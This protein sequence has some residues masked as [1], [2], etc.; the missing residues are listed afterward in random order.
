MHL[1]SNNLR[2][3]LALLL[4]AGG[5]TFA[6]IELA[7]E[8]PADP[9]SAVT[10]TQNAAG[11]LADSNPQREDRPLA[12]NASTH[13]EATQDAEAPATNAPAEI[14]PSVKSDAAPSDASPAPE[15]ELPQLG[16]LLAQLEA[17]W[18]AGK[19]DEIASIHAKLQGFAPLSSHKLFVAALTEARDADFAAMLLSALNAQADGDLLLALFEQESPRY[20]RPHSNS[21]WAKGELE[22]LALL[23][24][25]ALPS[26]HR[27]SNPAS[28]LS[29]L[30]KSQ[31]SDEQILAALALLSQ[32]PVEHQAP[33]R[34]ALD[35]LARDATLAHELRDSIIALRFQLAQDPTERIAM[36]GS[37]TYRQWLPALL[38][39]ALRESLIPREDALRQAREV[40]LAA[41]SD[42]NA[43][44]LFESYLN[45]AGDEGL[46]L[47]RTLL[48]SSKTP[49]SLLR[50]AMAALAES[51]GAQQREELQSRAA[52]EDYR[53]IYAMEALQA[54][55]DAARIEKLFA[56]A[57]LDD[58]KAS[59][60]TWLAAQGERD[61]W[62]TKGLAEDQPARVR[63]SAATLLDASIESERMRLLELGASDTNVRIRLSAVEKL[64]ALN[65]ETLIPWFDARAKADTQSTIRAAAASH[66]ESLRKQQR[67]REER[68][69]E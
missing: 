65:D 29:A 28:S 25:R 41:P 47:A 32:T 19:A 53:A 69:R 38:D 62:I 43:A 22:Y 5:G 64:G 59:A 15:A 31:L 34:D 48:D 39:L 45:H 60:L 66:A 30:V 36:L 51:D 18:R 52:S 49:V 56:S 13:R 9:A 46:T 7:S 10:F 16:E 58:V 50:R 6:A 14:K 27:A 44:A 42:P 55:G 4:L 54:A 21:E 57:Q 37:A 1:R 61:A 23:A 20:L 12:E 2:L 8:D 68:E 26:L 35:P 11:P 24:M 3:A 40:L 67:A 17:A 33:I 63:S